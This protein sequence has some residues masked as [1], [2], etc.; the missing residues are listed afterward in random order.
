MVVIQKLITVNT[1]NVWRSLCDLVQED[2]WGLPYKLV[3][4]KLIRPP[5][6]P[7]LD[8]PARLRHIV[9]GLFPKHPIR[10]T[11][12]WP[13][14]LSSQ[15]NWKIDEAELRTAARSLKTK[16]A[17][18]PDG[19]TNEV[20]KRIVSLKPGV[21]TKVYNN[22]LEN[23]VFPRTWK[24][25][26]LVLIRKGE[27]PLDKPSSYRPI[28][29]LDC[30][31]KLLEKILDNRLRTFLDENAG[32]HNRQFEFRKRRSIID[33]LNSLRETIIPNQKVRI[34]TL[35]IKNAFNSA[36]WN[37]IVE[38]LLDKDV[39]AYLRRIIDSYLE[40]RIL[41]IGERLTG[42]TIDVTCGVPQ[43]SVIGPTLW[44]VLYDGLLQMHLP[45]GVEYLAFA[46]DVALVARARDSIELEKLLSTSVQRVIQWLKQTGLELAEDKCEAMVITRTRTH[47]DMQITVN[48]HL[49]SS[50]KC[51]KYLSV[52]IDPKLSFTDH[53]RIVAAKAG[54]VQHLSRIMPNIS[55]ARPTKR[56]LLKNV[57]HSIL[58]YRSPVWVEDMSTKGWDTLHK[59]QRR[60]CLRVVSAYCTTS[61]D[62]AGVIAG[63]APLDLLA[64]E[65][66]WMHEKRRNQELAPPAEGIVDT[67]QRRWD[68]S[69]TGRWTHALI[70]DIDPWISRRHGETNF[71]LTQA[72][73]GQG[74]FA[75]YLKRFDKL[76]SS[77]CWF[78]GNPIDDAAHT[79]F[80]CDAWRQKRRQ[81]ETPLHTV[82]NAG[83]LVQTMLASK[84][85]WDMVSNML[86]DIIKSK[87]AEE[88]RRKAMQPD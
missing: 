84:A 19:I 6:I 55:A 77:E 32:I 44:N 33:H 62:A 11:I 1:V 27:K 54:K 82:L 50:A 69:N 31:G 65:R 36:P 76:E 71:H 85:N 43:G 37:A 21:L 34:L 16:I 22:C 17:P 24:N 48:G 15:Q 51:I 9:D 46:D 81:V 12:E 88:Q 30:L 38:G 74:C 13:L 87:E 7:E 40:N 14:D 3:M 83:N 60:I 5:Q 45:A 2:P 61:T 4:D 10:E 29:L 79:L 72:L 28:C 26:R 41:S 25:A 52:H 49:V 66:K 23:G 80:V 63:I 75:A 39:P 58:L 67:W 20:V 64:M 73:S 70:P 57:V 86:Q 8:T 68:S 18:G 47:N 78:C 59:L 53:A 42:T 35:D 56:K